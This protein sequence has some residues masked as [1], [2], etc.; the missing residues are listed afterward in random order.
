VSY[1]PATFTLAAI[2][3]ML[4]SSTPAFCAPPAMPEPPRAAEQ[5]RIEVIH[6]VAPSVVCIFDRRQQ[7][8]GSGVLIDA[9]G[10]GLT[11][12]HVI[13][14]LLQTGGGWGG[15]ADGRLYELRVLGID[16]TGDVA[17]FR[18]SG[19]GSGEGSGAREGSFPYSELGDSDAVRMGDTVLAMGNP[20]ML[21]DDYTPSVS[22]GI[23]TGV[24]RYQYGVRGNQLV[25]SDCIQTD[26]AINPGNSGGPLFDDRGRV[27]G[28]NGRIS[29]NTRGRFNVG[30]GYAISIN[31]IRRFIPALRAGLL[32][33]HGTLQARVGADGDGLVF[34]E[35]M[36]D[37]PAS[38]AG[39]RVG[40]RLL[41]F[42]GQIIDSPNHL[43]SLLGTYPEGWPVAIEFAREGAVQQAVVRLEPIVPRL[44]HPFEVDRTVNR[45]E[46]LRVVEAY[47][48]VIGATGAATGESPP[49]TES[50]DGA[51]SVRGRSSPAA[52]VPTSAVPELNWT[53]QRSHANEPSDTDPAE[54]ETWIVT[55]T[56][57]G[58]ER[59]SSDG[60]TVIR[61]D[62]RQAER[63]NPATGEA[64]PL[65]L[66]ERMALCTLYVVER[67]LPLA[68]TESGAWL[69][70]LH[71]GGDVLV[72]TGPDGRLH[73]GTLLEVIDYP[74]ARGAT[75]R[76]GFGVD[77]RLLHVATVRQGG[78]DGT[79]MELRFGEYERRG[80]RL[81]P[82]RITILGPGPGA[83]ERVVPEAG[84]P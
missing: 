9:D 6:R 65:P 80:G 60:D 79:T 33:R 58:A 15:L 30:F 43:A 55:V 66:P 75:A 23:V 83:V 56:P 26:A 78:E 73:G 29:V 50:T 5:S 3:S 52:T 28:I 76:L 12:Y 19:A 1:A 62:E 32:A 61:Y 41:R 68:P 57:D 47:R 59:R 37:A 11:N 2:W 51:T 69:D 70:V 4:L 54:P 44:E 71:G 48:A 16:P 20:F 17:M 45:A 42:D 13:A 84:N 34:T 8:G 63:V 46:A 67:L 49:P 25:Y 40:D 82:T 24:H 21:S 72:V 14:G 7:G 18:L 27:I 39:I 31:Q 38:R 74:V 10:L 22:R 36:R 81:R 35:V 64:T 77:D 53:V